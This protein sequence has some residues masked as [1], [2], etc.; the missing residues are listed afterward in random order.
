V[1]EK[2]IHQP[3]L[4]IIKGSIFDKETPEIINFTGNEKIN[5]GF[6][7]VIDIISPTTLESSAWLQQPLTV[8][9]LDHKTSTTGRFFSGFINKVNYLG[10]SNHFHQYKMVVTSYLEMLNHEKDCRIFQSM[11]VPEIVTQCIKPLNCHQIDLSKLKNKYQ[12]LEY[13]TQYNEST[14][15]FIKRLLS[16][17]GIHFYYTHA[18][19][20][21]CLVLTD[22]L[23]KAAEEKITLTQ[24]DHS[25][26]ENIERYKTPSIN[27]ALKHYSYEKS[28][29]KL[30]STSSKQKIKSPF[31]K[32]LEQYHFPGNHTSNQQG[33]QKL[34][35]LNQA[36][37]N[38]DLLTRFSFDRN[39]ALNTVVND[40]Q[41]DLCCLRVIEIKHRAHL[42]P[43]RLLN[44]KNPSFYKADLSL[45][46]K[47]KIFYPN[48]LAKP[49]MPGMQ[50]ATVTGADH[51]TVFSDN[52]N[53]IKARFNWDRSNSKNSQSS[54]W[55]RV[56]TALAGNGWGTKC[57][58]Q[59]GDEV[60]VDF[61]NADPDQ[62]IVIRQAYN[63]KKT[64][65]I[66][67][68]Q[69]EIN[70]YQNPN[71]QFAVTANHILF[72]DNSNAAN[73]KVNGQRD[74]TYASCVDHCI[75]VGKDLS[76]SVNKGNHITL[77]PQGEY[78][79]I[80]NQDIELT[81][82][83]HQLKMNN[84]EIVLNSTLV[85]INCNSTEPNKKN[86]KT[87]TEK[88]NKKPASK[89]AD[90]NKKEE[91]K[92]K[93]SNKAGDNNGNQS[94][95]SKENNIK[96]KIQEQEL[97]DAAIAEATGLSAKEMSDHFKP[98]SPSTATNHQLDM[99]EIMKS[100]AA[101]GIISNVI[102]EEK[103][104]ITNHVIDN[105]NDEKITEHQQ[106]KFPAPY[107]L[108]NH[109]S[110]KPVIS[111]PQNSHQPCK[112]TWVDQQQKEVLFW[113]YKQGKIIKKK[114]TPNPFKKA[115]AI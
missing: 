61:I 1:I 55:L 58:P 100:V 111:C 11:S 39:L 73:I 23:E 24:P 101:A 38:R 91:G 48:A 84:E 85:K 112:K 97:T 9:L 96:D 25:R 31:K 88:D 109:P 37:L 82:G 62:P 92:T 53:R 107:R 32:P 115:E 47:D 106:A 65:A 6:Q 44:E 12:P 78:Q 7:W 95:P 35:Q 86:K 87:S 17:A 52:M 104:L 114:L 94:T 54:C 46:A 69:A 56:S 30:I 20:S 45:I 67:H 83:Q 5:S 98:D 60:W 80:V 14:Y 76:H 108:K 49:M 10:Q 28:L 74:L 57:T 89:Q 66:N 77:A 63:D 99:N 103:K 18:Q 16:Q 75:S 41:S 26:K 13:C 3:F 19:N 27:H 29:E 22:Q 2:D 40:R 15:H 34:K 79:L 113:D 102:D 105:S 33:E 110:A 43:H 50:I 81:C 90:A 4:S 21:H 51:K 36:Q 64:T 93:N 68:K 70:G 42:E 8:K 72:N 71:E 59:N